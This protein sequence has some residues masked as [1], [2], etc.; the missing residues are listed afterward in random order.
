[1]SPT[2]EWLLATYKESKEAKAC[3]SGG[4]FRDGERH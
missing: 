4:I 2:F 3:L 1:M